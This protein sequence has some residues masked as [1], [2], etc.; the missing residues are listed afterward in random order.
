MPGET[1]HFGYTDESVYGHV[2]ALVR[3]HAKPGGV[4][5]DLGAG[6]GAIAEPIRDAGFDYVA[7]D[8]EPAGL[9]DLKQR[10]FEAEVC[11]LTRTGEVVAAIEARLGG[12][13]LAAI[14]MLDTLEHLTT[15][16]QTLAALGDLATRTGGAP[17]VVSIPNV[18]HFDLATKLLLGRWDLTDTGLLDRT[19]VTFYDARTMVSAFAATGWHQV[20]ANDFEVASSDQ[21]FP[22]GLATQSRLTPVGRLLYGIRSG[23]APAA[24]VNQFVRAYAPGEPVVAAPEPEV[25]EPFAS[26]LVRT[27]GRRPDTLHDALLSLAAQT[28]EDYEVLL[29]CHDVPAT[30]QAVV[31]G[32][33][34][35]MPPEF[36]A[37]VRVVP[38]TGGRRARPLNVGLAEA[39]GRYIVILD[40]DDVVMANWL[41]EFARMAK[42]APGSMV[43]AV[44]ARQDFVVG[45][46][47][48]S[49]DAVTAPACPYPESF[50]MLGHLIDN[51]SP[52]CGF[53][54]PRVCF[55]EF[56]VTFDDDLTVLEDWDVVVQLA[57][58]CGVVS[59]TVPTSV[60][61]RWLVGSH[62]GVDHS[63]AEWEAAREIVRG[64]LDARPVLLPP[65]EARRVRDLFKF[66]D[67]QRDRADRLEA[68]NHELHRRLR[69]VESVFKDTASWKVS[70]PLRWA[71]T[72]ARVARDRARQRRK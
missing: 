5:V 35:S 49:Y 61:R 50:D 21:H 32:I 41:E 17:L 12:R 63:D 22:D 24:L 71:G 44:V 30:A 67:H 46:G 47:H 33:V 4:V 29:L 70:A 20:A 54:F 45:D 7:F 38:V 19:H 6:Y 64:R 60:Y 1:Y 26:V 42:T 72:V 69:E 57:P 37:R 59:T 16:P 55:A 23:A 58:L 56:G 52:L 27:Q 9:D 39:R 14:A 66:H 51:W 15:G 11:D 2:V 28:L 31:D 43:R 3:A 13:P 48:R 65:G 62:S 68:E 36:V 40:D 53:A 10:G 34:A 25:A 18:T 8:L